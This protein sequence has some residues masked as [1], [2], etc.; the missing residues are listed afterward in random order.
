MDR[1]QRLAVHLPG[2]QDLGAAGLLD[3]DR[4]A[5]ALRR[6]R[7]RA[8]VCAL[9]ADVRGLRARAGQREHVRERH[10]LPHRRAGRTGAPRRLAGDLADGDQTGAAVAGAL[11]RRSD[12]A[13]PERLA[14]RRVGQL[15][16]ALDQPVHPQPPRGRVKLRNRPVPAHVERVR[17]G[18][19]PFGQRRGPGLD[20]ER[21]LLV[22]DHVGAL[23]VAGHR[24]TLRWADV[25]GASS[26]VLPALRGF[27]SEATSRRS[28][29]TAGVRMRQKGP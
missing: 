7:L 20:V 24:P 18:Q 6:L 13:L 17:G 21:L 12:L 27:V 14:Q 23:A 4:T 9:E 10:A 16:R 15:Q 22:D 5:E 8:E 26:G 11:Q 2:E 19:R 29:V 1:R 25:D 28:S 3:R